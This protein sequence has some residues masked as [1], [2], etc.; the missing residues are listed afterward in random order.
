[1][2]KPKCN[3][4]IF[5]Q[6]HIHS[7]GDT[8]A[9]LP[10]FK[11]N[12]KHVNDPKLPQPWRICGPLIKQIGCEIYIQIHTFVKKI[13]KSYFHGLCFVASKDQDHTFPP[14]SLTCSQLCFDGPKILWRD[15][16]F[17]YPTLTLTMIQLGQNYWLIFSY[18]LMVPRYYEGTSCFLSQPYFDHDPASAR[19]KLVTWL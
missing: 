6:V 17:C 18:V 12:S 3:L 7:T 1:M 11:T 10:K 13:Q 19:T 5:C 2:K 9:T 4:L 8:L 15:L 16:L 14:E